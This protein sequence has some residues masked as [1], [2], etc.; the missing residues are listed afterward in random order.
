MLL[1]D[2]KEFDN[3]FTRWSDQYLS[4]PSLFGIVLEINNSYKD[5]KYDVVETVVQ[6]GDTSHD[7]CM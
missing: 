2:L 1:H 3:D 7:C 6:Y 5:G 4:F